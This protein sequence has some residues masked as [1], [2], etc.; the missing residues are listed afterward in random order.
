MPNDILLFRGNDNQNTVNLCFWDEITVSHPYKV[1]EESFI[2]PS[3]DGI[4]TSPNHAGRF[5]DCEFVFHP[6]VS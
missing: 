5:F 1:L 4:R 2:Y 3:I 6:L